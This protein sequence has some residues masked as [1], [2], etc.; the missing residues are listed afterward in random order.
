MKPF[1]S[2]ALSIYIRSYQCAWHT[3]A[4]L[5]HV[6]HKICH[7]QL[8]VY[9]FSLALVRSFLLSMFFSGFTFT[10]HFARIAGFRSLPFIIGCNPSILAVV[11]N[12]HPH[13]HHYI[14]PSSP[15]E[16]HKNHHHHYMNTAKTLI[17]IITHIIITICLSVWILV[18]KKTI[19]HLT[20]IKWPFSNGSI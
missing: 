13:H 5:T 11:H 8:I 4:D 17:T 6:L 12:H 19:I 1:F 14:H 3:G 15:W 20:I 18:Q 16:H 9:T 2:G 7:P 10:F